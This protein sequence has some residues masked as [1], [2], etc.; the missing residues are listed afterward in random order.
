VGYLQ[1]LNAKPGAL[2]LAIFGAQGGNDQQYHL[3][4][5]SDWTWKHHGFIEL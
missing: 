2:S 4:H 3:V 1:S 5:E